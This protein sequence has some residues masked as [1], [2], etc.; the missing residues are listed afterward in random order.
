MVCILLRL[1]ELCISRQKPRNTDIC[2][3]DTQGYS[4]ISVL[5]FSYMLREATGPAF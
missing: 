2:K 5:P 3:W 1:V 4:Y